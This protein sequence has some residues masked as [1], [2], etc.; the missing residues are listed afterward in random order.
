MADRGRGS[1][2]AQERV[3][4]SVI[5]NNGLER[6]ALHCLRST[7]LTWRHSFY[8][9]RRAEKLLRKLD[10]Q[11]VETAQHHALR[12]WFA[13]L[14]NE[15]RCEVITA[16][17]R[18][19]SHCAAAEVVPA[20]GAVHRWRDYI[21]EVKEMRRLGLLVVRRLRMFTEARALDQWVACLHQV[22][23]NQQILWRS[24]MYWLRPTTSRALK[25]WR[26]RLRLLCRR[27]QSLAERARREMEE[28]HA[29]LSAQTRH[30]RNLLWSMHSMDSEPLNRPRVVFPDS[31]CSMC[32]AV[33]TPLR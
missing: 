4:F 7:F 14:R 15:Q 19:R 24:A 16:K 28:L 29:G 2:R 9:R 12:A 32:G 10:L 23:S 8:R 20:L 21:C 18:S 13:H 25:A 31:V 27:R 5:T 26:N 33:L 22:R 1:L 30:R 17:L 3:R 11:W 6:F